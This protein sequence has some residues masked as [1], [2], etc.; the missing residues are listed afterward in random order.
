M[1]YLRGLSFTKGADV[2]GENSNNTGSGMSMGM[3]SAARRGSYSDLEDEDEVIDEKDISTEMKNDQK[4]EKV[5]LSFNNK[6][7]S[8][9]TSWLNSPNQSHHLQTYGIGAKLLMKMGYQEGKGLGLNEE[10]IV[11]PIETAVRPKG[12]GVG[13]VRGERKRSDS[14][15]EDIDML[16]SDDESDIRNVPKRIDLFSV[17]E[18]L[19]MR[20]VKVPKKYITLSDKYTSSPHSDPLYNEVK[21]TFTLLNNL[22]EELEQVDGQEKFL[23]YQLK[24]LDFKMKKEEEEHNI[25]SAVLKI[26]EDSSDA[27]RNVN[28]EDYQ[29]QAI[30]R[31][32]S[33]LIEPMTKS[34][35]QIR[36]IFVSVIATV[37]PRLFEAYPSIEGGAPTPLVD[38]LT[39]W[40]LLYREIETSSTGNLNYFDS[41]LLTQIA[42]IFQVIITSDSTLDNKNGQ[43]LNHIHDWTYAPILIDP[44][45]CIRKLI[46][47]IIIPFLKDT[48]SEWSPHSFN[49]SAPTYIIDYMA[50]L[51]E[52]D[53]PFQEVIDIVIKKYSN[54]IDYEV[55]DS[56]WY[57]SEPFDTEAEEG[58]LRQIIRLNSVW[59]P[60]I[61]Q[62]K[63]T[64]GEPSKVLQASLLRFFTSYNYFNPPKIGTILGVVF[65][66]VESLLN[67]NEPQALILLQFGWGNN[68]IRELSRILDQTPIEAANWY[69]KWY[70][71]ITGQREKY[72]S[73]LI[74]IFDWYFNLALAIIAGKLARDNI[75]LPKI[76][77][78]M[79]PT[80]S[81]VSRFLESN[82]N[83]LNTEEVGSIVNVHG[84]PSYQLM[85]SFK[86]VVAEY[87]LEK[88]MLL[89]VERNHFHSALGHPLFTIRSGTGSKLWCYIHDDV[90]WVTRLTQGVEDVEYEPISLD[91]IKEYIIR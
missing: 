8:L 87:C 42:S 13:G 55:N 67:E 91:S 32:V 33:R 52:E 43:L 83:L 69:S 28:R 5:G 77:G 56:F 18:A 53:Y 10:G 80:A 86:D 35:S 1:S 16:S 36:P 76:E 51:P 4:P 74:E 29:I 82:E 70:S 81:E 23:T 61:Q 54:F 46:E 2:N 64:S 58:I 50:S 31:T 24:D 68:W 66:I 25:A 7:E 75:P 63:L 34:Y 37:I 41:L 9:N 71:F 62:G 72:H 48:L 38:A 3:M 59:I 90:L 78:N 20:D 21:E 26:V 73:K 40:S 14:K 65:R 22:N 27:V 12:L 44:Q 17:I 19:E 84:I 89:A 15:D 30:T 60:L 39:E 57:Q 11:K 6:N 79:W 45:L 88:G 47:D 49:D 85:S